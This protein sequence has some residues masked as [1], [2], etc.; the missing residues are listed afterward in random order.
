MSARPGG[1]G[2]GAARDVRS[3]S[4]QTGRPLE[5]PTTERER[6]KLAEREGF[7]PSV[8]FPLHTLS[9]RAP[10]TTRTSLRFR[11]NGLRAVSNQDSAK[12]RF[13]HIQSDISSGA[14]RLPR[15]DPS[16]R[17][18]FVIKLR[19]AFD[20]LR[21]FHRIAVD[22]LSTRPKRKPLLAPTSSRA[23]RA[24][25]ARSTPVIQKRGID[26]CDSALLERPLAS[27]CRT[28]GPWTPPAVVRVR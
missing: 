2:F 10:S 24:D 6:R 26:A 7:E 14:N 22:D 12:P 11:I 23:R 13:T 18:R 3:T 27:A 4:R 17:S 25:S 20:H 28:R 15:R 8:E 19:M 16:R 21:C 5:P 1:E 9:K